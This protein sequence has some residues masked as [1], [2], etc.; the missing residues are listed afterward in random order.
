VADALAVYTDRSAD[1]TRIY[2]LLENDDDVA[3]DLAFGI[4]QWI[5]SRFPGEG[6]DFCVLPGRELEDQIPSSAVVMWK[7]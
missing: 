6:L 4:E 1:G 2:V 7:R 3:L 5:Y